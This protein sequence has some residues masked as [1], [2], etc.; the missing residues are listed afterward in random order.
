[1]TMTVLDIRD[2]LGADF[3]GACAELT[4]AR[5]L[6]AIKDT[7]AVRASVAQ[8]RDRVDA[9]LDLYLECGLLHR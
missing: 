6:Q 4:E 8:C 5:R 7:P 1:M 3:A 2:E 9:V